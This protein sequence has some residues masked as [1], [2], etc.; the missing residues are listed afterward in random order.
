MTRIHLISAFGRDVPKYQYRLPRK[1]PAAEIARREGHFSVNLQ[2]TVK[3]TRY[4]PTF[5]PTLAVDPD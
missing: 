4:Q 5:V 1:N 2:R 3:H